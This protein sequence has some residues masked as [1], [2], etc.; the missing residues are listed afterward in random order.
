MKTQI[1]KQ[2]LIL[3]L[4]VSFLCLSIL[5]A[6]LVNIETKDKSSKSVAAEAGTVIDV[7]AAG[8]DALRNAKISR[9]ESPLSKV[10]DL[11]EEENPTDI[12]EFI[13]E[14]VDSEL[15]DAENQDVLQ[16]TEFITAVADDGEEYVIPASEYE[17]VEIDV[18]SESGNIADNIDINACMTGAGG[19]E[20][21]ENNIDWDR[22]VIAK[23]KE[24]ANVRTEPDKNSARAGKMEVN[25]VG[26]VL[27]V[28]DDWVHMVSG[29]LEGY[30]KKD[31]CYLGED[32]KERAEEV[33]DTV[34]TS[35]TKGLRIRKG[36][37]QDDGI[38]RTVEKGTKLVVADSDKVE[39]DYDE[40]EWV[41]VR[42]GNGIGFVAKEYVSI[43]WDIGVGM[44]VEEEEAIQ[45]EKEEAARKGKAST[46]TDDLILLAALIEGEGNGQPYEGKVAIANVVLNRVNSGAYP[47]SIYNVIYQPGQFGPALS[48]KV[49]QIILK[50]PSSS[51]KDAA[52]AALGGLNYIGGCTHFKPISS[53]MA[54]AVI[55]GHVFY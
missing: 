24:F 53:G 51:N 27:S 8:A 28:S 16:T 30:I 47:S 6:V 33:C 12:V 37:S 21:D 49:A 18:F 5:I 42:S 15:E 19:A 44:T 20:F 54:G 50:G 35:T 25:D 55:G 52:A 2:I 7:S 14:A 48:G 23:V 31:L 9:E 10:G 36:P 22:A 3:M 32:A 13:T 45:R 4:A 46:N 26:I 34:A 11:N 17:E 41:P 43:S 40:D 1:N 38:I 29:E 39:D